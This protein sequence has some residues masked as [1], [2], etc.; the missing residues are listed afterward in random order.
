MAFV[1][2][3]KGGEHLPYPTRAGSAGCA[4]SILRIPVPHRRVVDDVLRDAV[5]FVVAD[6]VFGAGVG[7]SPSRVD[8]RARRM[9]PGQR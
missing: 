7:L 8:R 6:D 3:V 5:Q 4:V 9:F 1:I 2:G